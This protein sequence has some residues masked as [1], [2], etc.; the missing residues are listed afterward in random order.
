M[1]KRRIVDEINAHLNQI[2]KHTPVYGVRTATQYGECCGSFPWFR[3][4]ERNKNIVM[5]NGC[6]A[7]C[8]CAETF[9]TIRLDTCVRVFAF[10][11]LLFQVDFQFI[12][13]NFYAWNSKM[14]IQ[15]SFT[16]PSKHFNKGKQCNF[17][18]THF[19]FYSPFVSVC[20]CFTFDRYRLTKHIKHVAM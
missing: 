7:L 1:M 15:A 20:N 11:W 16:A 14:K 4:S 2:Y 6:A 9:I 3:R 12:W 19:L 8:N 17:F 10:Q 13:F 5:L 18:A